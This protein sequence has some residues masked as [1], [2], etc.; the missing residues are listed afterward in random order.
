MTPFVINSMF[1]YCRDSL[2]VS[3]VFTPSIFI[4]LLP[5]YCKYSNL[6]RTFRCFL[7]QVI[8]AIQGYTVPP[9]KQHLYKFSPRDSDRDTMYIQVYVCFNKSKGEKLNMHRLQYLAFSIWILF[10]VVKQGIMV[11]H[12][13]YHDLPSLVKNT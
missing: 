9:K 2:I 13:R 3:I 12:Q 8:Q 10:T 4:S 11:V 7:Y 1:F 5:H 6:A